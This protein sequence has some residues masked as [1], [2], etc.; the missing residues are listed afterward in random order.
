MTKGQLGPAKYAHYD[1]ISSFIGVIF[2]MFYFSL[3]KEYCSLYQ[4]LLLYCTFDLLLIIINRYG[5][6]EILAG[7]VNGLFLV[8]IAFFI[9]SEAVEVLN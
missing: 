9:L 2:Q 8:F 4:G 3:G 1:D 5:R 6:A 7:F